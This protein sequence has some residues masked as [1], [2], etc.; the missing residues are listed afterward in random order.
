MA[1]S[2]QDLL[3]AAREQVPEIQVAELA[4]RADGGDS[5]LVVDVREQHEWDEGH[6][7]GSVHVPRGFLEGRIAGVASPD[8]ELVLSCA[9]GN[10]SLL[11]A[12]A[13]QEMGYENV[14]SLAG[15]FTRWKQS[16]QHYDVPRRLSAPQRS[17]YARHISIPEVGES[18]QLDLLG[19]RALLIGAGGLGSPAAYYLAAAGV[20]TIGLVDDDVVDES[21]LQRQIIHTTDR[22]GMLKG[23]S[24]KVAINALNPDVT[25]NVHPFRVNKDNVLD[26]LADYDVI[27]DGADNFPTRYLLNDAALMTRTPLVHASILRFEGHASVFL[28]YEGPCYRCLFPEPPPPDM[29][30]SCGEAGVLGVLCGVM[31]N[32][33]ANEAIKVLLGIG[34]TLAGRLL[35]YDALGMTFTELKVRRDPNCPA[36]GPDAQLEFRDYDAWCAGRAHDVTAVAGAAS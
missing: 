28:P 22:V 23:E 9:S 7:P 17:R 13:L 31:G 10:R 36:C 11:A 3:A 27:V 5:P 4:S 34:D 20:G 29:A 32:I 6:I 25:V 30:P 35:I 15:G 12:V 19:S 16:G 26:L 18:G 33:Q 21:N 24:A 2:Y 14:S 1:R 8:R